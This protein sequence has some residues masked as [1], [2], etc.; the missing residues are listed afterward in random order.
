MYAPVL[1]VTITLAEKH[2]LEAE[3]QRHAVNKAVGEA[4]D[5][6]ANPRRLIDKRELRG[7]PTAGKGISGHIAGTEPGHGL[8]DDE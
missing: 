1:V 4:V 3:R 8:F 6:K 2:R 7:W 5:V